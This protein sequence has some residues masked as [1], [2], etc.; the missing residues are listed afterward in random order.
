MS[1]NSVP[2]IVPVSITI[3]AVILITVVICDDCPHDR[4][5]NKE[6]VVQNIIVGDEEWIRMRYEGEYYF[7]DAYST[8]LRWYRKDGSVPIYHDT[9][10]GEG[11]NSLE[12]EYKRYYR[13]KDKKKLAE[14]FEQLSGGPKYE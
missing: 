14:K 9:I 6:T 5:K 8:T 7:H 3:M 10:W 1:K 13:N 12:K 11:Q 4:T 2:F